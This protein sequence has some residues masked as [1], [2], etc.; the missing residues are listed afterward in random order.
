MKNLTPIKNCFTITFAILIFSNTFFTQEKEDFSFK[1]SGYV[2]TDLIYDSRQTVSAREGH[3]LLF[4]ANKVLDQNQ[5]DINAQSNFNILS[6]QSRLN[7]RI[8]GP[9]ALGAKTSSVIEAEFFGHSNSDING[10]RLRLAFIKL[11]WSNTSLIVGQFWHPLFITDVFANVVSFNTGIPF[12]PFSR[13]PQVRLQ[14][15]FDNLTLT[16]TAYTQRDFSSPGPDGTTSDYMR[17]SGL[18]GFNLNA[19]VKYQNFLFGVGGD[20]KTLRPRLITAENYSTDENIKSYAGIAFA[21]YHNDKFTFKAEGTYGGNL[22][23]LLMLGGYAVYEKDQVTGVQKYTPLNILSF[24]TDISYGKQT[25]VGIFAGYAE[26]KGSDKSF[27]EHFSRGI[28][29]DY[30]YRISPRVIFNLD[31][32]RIAG[33][34]EYT[35]ASYGQFNSKGTVDNSEEV[36]NLRVLTA[37]YLFF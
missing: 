23:D 26:N 30:L 7:G 32:F 31:S 22:N 28:N 24:W 5:N 21:K 17:N 15:S 13:N 35:I 8:T 34:L 3:L 16:A 36:G 2:K 33:E 29:I 1:L 4:P 20:F 12:Q 18:P 11:Q 37:V 25:E 9:E 27:S 6:I 19:M 10:F 14:H